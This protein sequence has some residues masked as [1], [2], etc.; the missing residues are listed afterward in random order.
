MS[1]R[2]FDWVFVTAWAFFV[3]LI[4]GFWTG[5]VLCVM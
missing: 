3:A 1:L 5:V 4:A 2:D